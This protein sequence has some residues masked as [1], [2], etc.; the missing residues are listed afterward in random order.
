MAHVVWV[1]A[2]VA[3]L[4]VFEGFEGVEDS[5]EPEDHEL[6]VLWGA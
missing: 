2:V 1:V 3:V 5:L 6:L 4:K